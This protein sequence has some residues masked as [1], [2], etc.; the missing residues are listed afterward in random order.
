MVARPIKESIESLVFENIQDHTKLDTTIVQA[1]IGCVQSAFEG[2]VT[3]DDALQHIQGDLITVDLDR[4]TGKALSFS[5]TEFG[6]PNQIFN[7]TIISDEEGCYLAGA[8]VAKEAQGYGL[9]KKMNEY[10]IHKALNRGCKLLFT[11]TQNPRV[12]AGIEA[13]LSTFQRQ[14]LIFSYDMKRILVP[15]CY[16][17][18]LTKTKPVDDK[19][20][21]SELDYDRG[22]AYIILFRLKYPPTLKI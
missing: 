20:S 4:E 1:I 5:S 15:G 12:Q 9:Y 11:R 16:G 17:S 14:K 3:D 6:S 10:R 8:T 19:I 2:G 22:D 21:F 18:Q 13:T 7:Q